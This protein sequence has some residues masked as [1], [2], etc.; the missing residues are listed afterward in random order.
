MLV[1]FDADVLSLLLD[2]ANESPIDP[3]TGQPVERTTDRLDYLIANLQKDKARVL[4]PAPA[5]AEFLVIADEDGPDYLSMID[6]KHIF[7][8]EPFDGR[9]AIEA[10]ASTRKAIAQGGKKSG[11]TGT[12]QCVKTDRQIV[13]IAK[14]RGVTRI[15]SNDSDMVNIAADSGID[16]IPVWNLPLPPAEQAKLFE[17]GQNHEGDTNPSTS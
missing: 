10:A 4:L 13:A 15:Y 1:A 2:P 8:T 7:T 11:T 3:T 16:V 5:L 12:W 17:A 14:T 9:A 6:Q